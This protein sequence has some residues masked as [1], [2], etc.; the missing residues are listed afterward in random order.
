MYERNINRS[1][2]AIVRNIWKMIGNYK[3]NIKPT[4]MY[5][6]YLL[7]FNSISHD[8]AA[9]RTR[10]I[11]VLSSALESKTHI[12]ALACNVLYSYL[13]FALP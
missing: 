1:S 13:P 4:C 6:L 5:E 3:Q 7:V 2:S 12:H 11:H 9:L 8:F 10:E